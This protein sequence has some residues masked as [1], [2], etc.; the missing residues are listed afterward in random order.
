M[1]LSVVAGRIGVTAL[2]VSLRRVREDSSAIEKQKPKRESDPERLKFAPLQ[3]IHP[4]SSR[5]P[6]FA[7]FVPGLLLPLQRN[8]FKASWAKRKVRKRLLEEK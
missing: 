2:E 6:G 1:K 5:Q 3:V 8:N 4:L 7:D